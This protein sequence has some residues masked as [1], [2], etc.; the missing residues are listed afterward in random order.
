MNHVGAQRYHYH[1]RY[2]PQVPGDFDLAT[3]LVRNDHG[4][5]PIAAIPIHTLPA[6]RDQSPTDVELPAM[7]AIALPRT[8][9][10]AICWV[11][12]T[13]LWL[14]VFACLVALLYRNLRRDLG[15]RASAPRNQSNDLNLEL[16]RLLALASS[17]ALT[18]VGQATLER[19]V[20]QW[21]EDR[22][23]VPASKG[24]INRGAI[25][26]RQEAAPYLILLDEYLYA[27]VPRAA[28]DL[29]NLMKSALSEAG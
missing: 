18:P 17:G 4:Q 10:C 28:A 3:L 29:S 8:D 24:S 25:A 19:L 6:L 13:I 5:Y 2:T 26:Q 23:D 21:L 1:I 20:L 15:H 22:Y 12:I 27:S 11:I 7:P 9:H 14:V 16:T